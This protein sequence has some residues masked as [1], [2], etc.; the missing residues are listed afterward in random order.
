ML[1]LIILTRQLS[2]YSSSNDM[3]LSQAQA[4]M[5]FNDQTG[6]FDELEYI[7]SNG[8]YTERGKPTKNGNADNIDR[9]LY[10]D[11]CQRENI[12]I[13]NRVSVNFKL[14]QALNDFRLVRLGTVNLKLF[15]DLNDFRLMRLGTKSYKLIITTAIW[16]VCYISLNPNMILAHD[17][18]LKI[19]HGIYPFWRSDKSF[20]VA[21]DSLNFYDR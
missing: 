15:Q 13:L 7:G 4:T 17:E 16:K 5:F 2:T 6:Y 1:V 10:L 20:S 21:K 19:G 8:G 11:I 14:F 3:I 9:Y 18:A 12:A